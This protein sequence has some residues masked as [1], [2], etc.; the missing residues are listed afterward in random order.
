MGGWVVGGV[1][2]KKSSPLSHLMIVQNVVVVA[3][4]HI[5]ISASKT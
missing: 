2:R 5:Y 4:V 3:R 1:I